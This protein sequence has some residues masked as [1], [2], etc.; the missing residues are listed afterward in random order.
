MKSQ[1]QTDHG[2]N[3]GRLSRSMNAISRFDLTD[4][5]IILTGGA[6]LYGR[7]LTSDLATVQGRIRHAAY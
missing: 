3:I 5:V 7:G 4:K 2:E 1:F 6:G